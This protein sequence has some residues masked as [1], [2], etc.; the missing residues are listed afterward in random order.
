MADSEQSGCAT[1]I[2]PRSTSPALMDQLFPYVVFFP[3]H[4]FNFFHRRETTALNCRKQEMQR[5]TELVKIQ[6]ENLRNC[7]TFWLTMTF[8]IHMP[9]IFALLD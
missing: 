5:G 6:E 1:Q 7:I 4:P 3:S 8:M 9:L 2:L